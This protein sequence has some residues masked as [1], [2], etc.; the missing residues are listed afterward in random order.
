MN[1]DFTNCI[2]VL[3]LVICVVTVSIHHSDADGM[4][5]L[6][7]FDTSWSI[8][9]YCCEDKYNTFICYYIVHKSGYLYGLICGIS[10]INS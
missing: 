6:Y 5:D 8:L 3:T 9:N 4:Y 10:R 7:I 2:Y 1:I